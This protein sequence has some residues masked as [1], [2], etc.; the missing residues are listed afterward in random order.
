VTANADEQREYYASAPERPRLHP[1]RRP[2]TLRHWQ[3]GLAA[4][5]STPPARVLELGAGMGRFSLL[6]AD[7]GFDVTA[8]DVSDVL[9]ERLRAADSG[10]RIETTV[11]DAANADRVFDRP[12]DVVVGFFFLHHLDDFV[13]TFRAARALLPP[14]GRAVFCEPNG[15]NPSFYLQILFSPAMTFRG[16]RGL[17]RM[18]ARPLGTAAREAGLQLLPILRYGLLPPAIVDRPGGA[19]L[20]RLCAAAMPPIARAFQ[21]I[22]LE[23]PA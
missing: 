4:A 10:G 17:A 18:R 21:T 2:S 13:P 11:A 16:E 23:R 1:N 14:G 20:D 15:W 6:L 19:A 22:V 12:F 9:L 5:G 8:L 7:A 3:R